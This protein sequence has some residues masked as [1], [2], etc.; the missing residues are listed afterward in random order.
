M[1]NR[2]LDDILEKFKQILTVE[3]IMT[4]RE[5]FEYYEDWMDNLDE[6]NFD[7]LP[8]KNLKEYWNRKDKEFHRITSEIIVN[9]DLELWNLIDYFKDRDFYF[10]E[11]NGEIVGLV[12]FS[13]LNKQYVRILFY[14]IISELELKMHK[15]CNEKYRENEEEI[16]RK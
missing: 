1:T 5:A 7:I 12:H 15:V 3:K 8:A 10:V 9:T 2:K 13:D 14:I 4:P 11:Q 6:T 16:K